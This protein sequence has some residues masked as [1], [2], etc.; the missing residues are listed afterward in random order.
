MYCYVIFNWSPQCKEVHLFACLPPF[1]VVKVQVKQKMYRAG[2]GSDSHISSRTLQKDGCILS[3][4]PELR[5]F[6]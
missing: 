1:R 3:W 6:G 5:P 4:G 2:V